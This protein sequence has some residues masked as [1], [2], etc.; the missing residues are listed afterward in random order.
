MSVLDNVMWHAMAGHQAALAERLGS[1][2]RFHRD[3]AP[4]CAISGSPES[5]SDLTELVGPG[6]R[7]LLFAPDMEIP[8]P[9]VLDHG[10]VCLQM[11]AGDLKPRRGLDLVDLT[12]DDVDEMVALV[13]EAQP[14]PFGPRTIEMG[15]Y[16]GYREEGRLVAMAGER[17]RIPGYTE[18]SAVCTS[19]DQRGKGL[20]GEL[21]LAVVEHIRARGDE[22]FL[23]VHD[24]NHTAISLYK[25]LGFNVR[26]D[27]VDVL[28]LRQD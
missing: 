7:A 5:W 10:F 14:G 4:F 24:E 13:N 21:T 1:A 8:E 15:R 19:A 22:A 16:F 6:H 12:P 28:I 20:G 18:V 2:G 23:H 25:S 3:V 27:D 17:A 11:I 9:W 26:R